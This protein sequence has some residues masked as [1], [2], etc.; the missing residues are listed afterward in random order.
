MDESLKSSDVFERLLERVRAE[1]AKHG[2]EDNYGPG[3]K[4][5][6]YAVNDNFLSDGQI[7]VSLGNVRLF[8]PQVIR[9]LQAV[10]A[11]FP[12]WDIVVSHCP[13]RGEEGYGRQAL[14]V[15]VRAHEV[16]DDLIR[17]RLPPQ[18]R[19][20]VYPDGRARR[21]DEPFEVIPSAG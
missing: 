15:V 16:I 18:Y 4:M 11:D 17:E 2:R 19:S 7:G 10:L 13:V 3:G 12:G 6:D 8:E 20:I 9:G 1:M 21:A 5:G 14:G